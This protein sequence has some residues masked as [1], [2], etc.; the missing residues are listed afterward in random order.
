MF[1]DLA[2]KGSP[3]FSTYYDNCSTPDKFYLILPEIDGTSLFEYMRG[4]NEGLS[5]TEAFMIGY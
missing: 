3:Y 5:Q 1:T 2:N 4:R